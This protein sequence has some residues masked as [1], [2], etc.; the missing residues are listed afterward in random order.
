[1]GRHPYSD[2]HVTRD[3]LCTRASSCS[4]ACSLTPYAVVRTSG[5][6]GILGQRQGRSSSTRAHSGGSPAEVRCP[7]EYHYWIPLQPH[8]S[9]RR[10][11]SL[12]TG[13]VEGLTE[14]LEEASGVDARKGF[15]HRR[16]LAQLTAAWEEGK[17]K[18]ETKTEVDAVARASRRAHLSSA[19]SLGEH[20][21]RFQTGIRCEHSGILSSQ[22][23]LF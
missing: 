14:T 12:S 15:A 18:S 19:R 22:A 16:E 20:H 10:F 6:Y 21:V 2:V 3:S 8:S 17:I 7:R 23:V 4:P 1:M 9:P 11:S 5:F 13:T